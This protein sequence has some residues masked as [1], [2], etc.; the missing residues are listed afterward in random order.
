MRLGC[1]E[2]ERT[3]RA[4]SAQLQKAR[5]FELRAALSLARLYHATG[6]DAGARAVLG[7]AL[8]GFAPR[9]EFPEIGQALALV[10]DVKATAQS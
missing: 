2:G 9:A 7:P 3:A 8:E 10:A 5:S 4:G 1:S 6:R